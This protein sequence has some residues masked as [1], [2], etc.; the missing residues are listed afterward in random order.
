MGGPGTSGT[1]DLAGNSQ[2][3]SGLSVAA[4]AVACDQ[5]IGNSSTASNCDP[6]L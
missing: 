5:V 6:D 4:G 3:V 2:Q 1:L